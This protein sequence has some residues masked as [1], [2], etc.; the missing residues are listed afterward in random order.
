MKTLSKGGENT[1]L[2]TL[3][4]SVPIC[5]EYEVIKDWDFKY[6][7]PFWK[8]KKYRLKNGASI[9]FKYNTFRVKLNFRTVQVPKYLVI[10]YRTF[11]RC[12]W[13]WI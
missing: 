2:D 9:F 4:V 8:A 12:I 10:S 5:L 11:K 3:G 7:E 1:M 13:V 6:T